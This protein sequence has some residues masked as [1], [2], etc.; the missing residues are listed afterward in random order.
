MLFSAKVALRAA[1]ATGMTVAAFGLTATSANAQAC[2]GA[3][4]IHGEGATLQSVAQASWASSFASV[5]PGKTVTYIGSGS[6]AGLNSWG[7][8]GGTFNT[9]NKYVATDDAATVPQIAAIRSAAGGAGAGQDVLTV[10]VTQAAIAIVANPPSGCTITQISNADLE[11]V[12]RGLFDTWNDISSAS[13]TCTGAITRV[14][15]SNG[16]GTTYQLKQYFNK[17]NG[18]TIPATCLSVGPQ[19]WEQLQALGTNNTTWPS[20][21]PTNCPAT[22]PLTLAGGVL[23]NSGSNIGT[24]VAGA[25]PGGPGAGAG[26]IGYANLADVAATANTVLLQVQNGSGY[27]GPKTTIGN[28]ANCA[29]A[30]YNVP[31]AALSSSTAANVDWST[32][33]GVDPSVSTGYSICTLTYDVSLRNSNVGVSGYVTAGMTAADAVTV[34]DYLGH[35]STTSLAGSYYAALPPGPANAAAIAVSLID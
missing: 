35:A 30:S 11:K 26:R 34:Q 17:I 28:N 24:L 29:A 15:R 12:F 8:S 25:E 14:V 33:Y 22:A 4:P 27:A 3:S 16:S 20:G 9:L 13:G 32:V 31:S 2:S 18:A 23:A 21:D 7:A 10:P 5:C 6:S 1:L 19:T